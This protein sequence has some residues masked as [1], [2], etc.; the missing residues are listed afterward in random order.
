MLFTLPNRLAQ[1]LGSNYLSEQTFGHQ[2]DEE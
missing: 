2:D 1:T